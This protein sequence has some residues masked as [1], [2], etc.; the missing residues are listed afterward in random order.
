MAASAQEIQYTEFRT[1]DC[2]SI[3]LGKPFA[4]KE[5]LESLLQVEN[6][7]VVDPD[8]NE[9]PSDHH[10]H[11][12][13]QLISASSAPYFVGIS[14]QELES[15]E[16]DSG[17]DSQNVGIS[18]PRERLRR[19]LT[20]RQENSASSQNQIERYFERQ[21]R[22]SR[23][24]S[25]RKK[26]IA[27]FYKPLHPH[28]YEFSEKF[29]DSKLR[30]ALNDNE[31]ELRSLFEKETGTGIYSFRMFTDQFCTE[32]IQEVEHFEHSGMPI[33]R[34][35]TMNNYG[36]ILDEIGFEPFFQRLL[37]YVKPIATL[38]YGRMGATLDSHHAFI[39]QYKI[40][41][42]TDLGFHYDESE[43][44]LNVCL[45]RTFIGGSLY[46]RG[47]LE[48]PSTHSENFEFKHVPGLGILHIGKHR[49]G[50]NKIRTG[51]RYNLIVWFRSSVIR[52]ESLHHC[53][54]CSGP[55]GHSHNEHHEEQPD[56]QQS[57]M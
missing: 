13:A 52:E 10:H 32:L 30:D 4:T 56:A 43:V 48:D 55:L 8:A 51:E 39:V 35:N 22:V 5:I 18:D 37:D 38:F 15:L 12:L 26:M 14:E 1:L 41:E 16:E 9:L 36:V 31:E 49:H 21:Q 3:R 50:A 19:S 7:V 33:M 28:L 44:T 29:V 47:L 27:Q 53:A 23:M 20:E 25:A 17:P 42:D 54:S 24:Q 11:H 40:G 34:P 6:I 57:S 46:F 45:G 2:G